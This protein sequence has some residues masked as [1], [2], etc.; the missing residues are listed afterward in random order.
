MNIRPK[1]YADATV[2]RGPQYFDYD[3]T[4]LQLG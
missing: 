2:K 3:N 4:E 1:L